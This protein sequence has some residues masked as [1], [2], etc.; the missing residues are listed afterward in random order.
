MGTYGD[1]IIDPFLLEM[2]KYVEDWHHLSHLSSVIRIL[3]PFSVGD[4]SK[5]NLS[6]IENDQHEIC[7]FLL[8]SPFM[9]PFY[10][11]LLEMGK[12]VQE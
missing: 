5:K 7:L 12:N 4:A 1:H 9:T 6:Q 2:G 8:A 10:P 11:F 3:R